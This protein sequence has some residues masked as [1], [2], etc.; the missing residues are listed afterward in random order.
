MPKGRPRYLVKD[1]YKGWPIEC[2]HELPKQIDGFYVL[3]DSSGHPLR[4]GISGKKRQD[5]RTRIYNEYHLRKKWRAVDHFSVFTFTTRTWFDQ[6]ER[7]VLAAVGPALSGNE[8]A[9]RIKSRNRPIPPPRWKHVSNFVRAKVN[10]KG[11]VVVGKEHAGRRVRVELGP[12][13][14]G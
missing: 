4:V 5:I 7:L 8:H 9:G 3:Y 6:V 13:V 1:F 11:Q 14:R 2:L 10:A 12:K